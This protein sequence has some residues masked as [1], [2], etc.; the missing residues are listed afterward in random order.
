M[1][2]VVVVA[3]GGDANKRAANW[4]RQEIKQTHVHEPAA[5][6]VPMWH[7]CTSSEVAASE[8]AATFSRLLLLH[9]RPKKTNKKKNRMSHHRRLRN[10]DDDEVGFWLQRVQEGWAGP[11]ENTRTMTK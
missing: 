2:V 11:R 4:K 8:R 9:P 3:E 7:F 1:V 5:V 10:T 6:G